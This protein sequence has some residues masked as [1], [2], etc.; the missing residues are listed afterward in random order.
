[1]TSLEV[2]AVA[3]V[4]WGS[5]LASRAPVTL[6]K[7]PM[8]MERLVAGE[9]RARR[10]EADVELGMDNEGREGEEEEEDEGDSGGCRSG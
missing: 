7:S 5:D 9:A 4:D 1:M 2:G 8:E 3:E 10:A 6:L